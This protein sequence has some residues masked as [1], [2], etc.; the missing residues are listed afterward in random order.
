[1]EAKT[2]ERCALAALIALAI[3]GLACVYPV[4]WSPDSTKV[5]FPVFGKDGLTGLVI[6]DISGKAIRKV[7]RIEVKNAELSPGAWSPDGKWIAYMVFEEVAAPG[8]PKPKEADKPKAF[9]ASLVLRDADSGKERRILAMDVQVKDDD[10]LEALLAYGPQWT[11][12]SNTL[13]IRKIAG[14][15]FAIIAADTNG[16][17][18]WEVP[19]RGEL[20]LR[21]AALSP[22]G[23]HLAYV[24]ELP[25][26][27]DDRWALYV[28]DVK[29]RTRRQA[30]TM[31]GLDDDAHAMYGRPAW[32]ADSRSVYVA[33]H[34][35]HDDDRKVASLKRVTI[36]TGQA[37]TVWQKED[38]AIVGISVSSGTGLVALDY[39]RPSRRLGTD[40]YDPANGQATPIHFGTH[41]ST[42]ISPNGKW[43]AFCPVGQKGEEFLGAVVSAD[44]SGL[45]FFVPESGLEKAIPEIVR[46]RLQ[47]AFEIILADKGLEK[48]LADAGLSVD[49][50][51][52]SAEDL[53]KFLKVLAQFA[54]EDKAPLLR[55]ALAYAGVQVLF[56]TL[57][58][59][60][61]VDRAA[62]AED[63]RQAVDAFLKAYPDHALGPELKKKLGELL[64][65]KAKGPEKPE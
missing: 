36:K 55:E 64:E 25:D 62:F 43:V 63:A 46:D 59:Q 1:M 13:A 20:A 51:L 49:G 48:R 39:K 17:M 32:S 28:Y 53:R 14:E 31:A 11:R 29:K 24:S 2:S 65:R 7:A 3:Y 60:E 57:G 58:E 19:L 38:A 23:L 33:V 27:K 45:R 21:T 34:E 44:G 15:R 54:Q 50:E 9:V 5:V 30:V 18:Q 52:N 37:K 26:D 35:E 8:K 42:E 22:D 47:G 40:V 16:K 6:T 12:D 61:P 56:D 41:Y 4:A 10:M